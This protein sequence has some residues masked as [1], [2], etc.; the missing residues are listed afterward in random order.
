MAGFVR[1]THDAV[2]GVREP[3]SATLPNERQQSAQ[4][5][6]LLLSVFLVLLIVA[7]TIG[8]PAGVGR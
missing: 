6:A 4:A 2:A 3:T 7:L 8:T 1:S 5:I